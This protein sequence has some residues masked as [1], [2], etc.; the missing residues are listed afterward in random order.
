MDRN[1]LTSQNG[2]GKALR[3]RGSDTKDNN[4]IREL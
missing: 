1:F 3:E 2:R 4:Y